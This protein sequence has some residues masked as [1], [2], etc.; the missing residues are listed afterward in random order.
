MRTAPPAAA[1]DNQSSRAV[2]PSQSFVDEVAW[3]SALGKRRR[4]P[5]EVVQP[6]RSYIARMPTP[7]SGCDVPRRLVCDTIAHQSLNKVRF[8]VNALSWARDGRRAVTANQN[9]EFTL[10]NG[11]AFN[12][13]GLI[14]AHNTAV[15]SLA[16]SRSGTTMISGDT[17]GAIKYWESTMTPMKEILGTHQGQAV[18]G[19]DFAP[20]D[21]KFCSCADDGTVRIWDWELFQEERILAGHGWDVKTCNWHPSYQLIASGSKDN[22]VKMWDPRKRSCVAT[23]YGHKHT[24]MKVLWN[25]VDAN[26]LLTASRDHTL[27]LYDIRVL[28]NAETFKGHNREVT[29]IAW[30]PFNKRVFCS[31][32]YDGRVNHWLVGCE[33]PLHSH[34]AHEQ[35]IWD[36]DFHPVGHVLATASN[37]HRV[38][39]W[40]RA[41]P[42]DDVE[43]DLDG[44]QKT[45]VQDRADSIGYV[46]PAVDEEQLALDNAPRGF[47]P[48]FETGG[49]RYG[50]D[51]RFGGG[52]GRPGGGGF[53]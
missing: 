16:W 46:P 20:S 43:R 4:E 53:S 45:L 25:A 2:D 7:R 12:F 42:G 50:P 38:K 44:A 26:W 14:A 27:K 49:G 52:G 9:G 21:A 22:Q 5:S 48:G 34:Y 33:Q 24:V 30:H 6:V 35:A 39:F 41:R 18:R 40:V 8:P 32:A 23:L 37:D 3:P 19:L 47:N 15:R 17:K 1:M 13:E 28:K 36:M 29:S 10:W 11:Q 31:G 51:A